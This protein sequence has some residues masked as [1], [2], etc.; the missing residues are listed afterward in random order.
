MTFQWFKHHVVFG[1]LFFLGILLLLK[2]DDLLEKS[3]IDII[4]K[5][6]YK[7]DIDIHKTLKLQSDLSLEQSKLDQNEQ[8]VINLNKISWNIN[9][10]LKIVFLRKRL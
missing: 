8:K 4:E 3:R 2:A 1:T 6:E 7:Y 9:I 10:I 5:N